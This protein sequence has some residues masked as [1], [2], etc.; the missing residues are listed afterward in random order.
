MCVGAWSQ[1]GLVKD[2]DILDVLK[3]VKEENEFP[4][5]W[6]AIHTL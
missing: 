5:G 6:D 3:E 4:E 1:L 2:N